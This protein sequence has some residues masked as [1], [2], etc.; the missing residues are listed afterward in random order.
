MSIPDILRKISATKREEL[1]AYPRSPRRFT[2]AAAGQAPPL[3]F[4][5]ALG[6]PGLAVI[7]EI[8]KASPSAG[9]IADAD[10][11]PAVI[12]K[13]YRSAGA[14]AISVLT[15][16]EYFKG[17]PGYL[18]SARRAVADI[19]LLRKDFII[20]ERQIY[21]ARALGAD[22]FL[23]IAAIL[24]NYQL[25]DFL[26]LGRGLGM[27]PLVE[28]HDAFELEKA[29]GAGAMLLG[30]NNRDLRSFE[31]DLANSA[32]LAGMM[33]AGAV[34]ISESGVGSGADSALIQEWGYDA[35]LVGETLMRSGLDG[36]AAMMREL[37]GNPHE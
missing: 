4:A 9:I 3:D 31:V 8:K 18:L 20:D 19:P 37:K 22:S 15:D 33:P 23:L 10:F 1:K 7:A 28:S 13:A 34:K 26:A 14:D 29:I 35:V 12:A 2:A 24:D 36:V 17:A 5:A 30:I 16:V 6:R 21:E 27:E 25:T 11:D 32:E